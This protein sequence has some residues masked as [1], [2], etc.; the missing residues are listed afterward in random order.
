MEA[1]ILLPDAAVLRQIFSARDQKPRPIARAT[2]PFA[3]HG[4]RIGLRVRERHEPA[5]ATPRRRTTKCTKVDG[6]ARRLESSIRRLGRCV[7]RALRSSVNTPSGDAWTANAG[8]RVRRRKARGATRRSARACGVKSAVA[9]FVSNHPVGDLVTTDAD[10]TSTDRTRL[11][12]RAMTRSSRWSSA[13][14][15]RWTG[16]GPASGSKKASLPMGPPRRG[17]RPK[18]PIQHSGGSGQAPQPTRGSTRW[19]GHSLVALRL[20]ELTR[21]LSVPSDWR[22]RGISALEPA[23]HPEHDANSHSTFRSGLV[24]GRA[25]R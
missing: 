18:R 17:T 8:R 25:P 14:A 5:A 6:V 4:A 15:G 23:M 13:S 22:S 11:S 24:R 12:L 20:R 21:A 7:R 10:R 1:E 19:S 3:G 9:A 2:I 16:S